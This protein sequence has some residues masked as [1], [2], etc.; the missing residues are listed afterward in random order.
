VVSLGR[1]AVAALVLITPRVAPVRAQGPAYLP[2][3][4]PVGAYLD[5]LVAR[6]ALP[7][8]SSL[9][10]PYIA[11]DVVTA[12][13]S[14]LRA[15]V[16]KLV[17][18]RTW[19][20]E[21]R[22]AALRAAVG[23]DIPWPCAE[24]S[25]VPLTDCSALQR[26]SAADAGVLA[27]VSLTPF[28]TAQTS[29]RRELMLAE[30]SG[31]APPG[32]DIRFAL[33]SGALAGV[34]R[35]RVD[36]ALKADPEFTGKKDRSITA[37][38]Q[39]AYMV[40]RSRL[41][42]VSAGRVARNWGPAP[43]DGLQ[44]GRYADTY[45]HLYLRLGVESLHLSSIVAR[46]DDMTVGTDSVAERYFT[47]HR[48]SAR[49]KGV[50][51]AASEAVVYG[52]IGR[53]F[54]PS[55]ANP[56]SLLDLLQ[57]TERKSLNVNYALDLAW[58]TAG[59]G[60]YA[61]QFLVDDFQFDRCGVRCQE[62]ASLGYSIV[63]EAMPFVGDARSFANY[64]RVTNLTYRSASPWER[65]TSFDL[66]LGR[67]QS[68]FDELRAGVELAPPLGGPLRL[69]G[70]YRR[71]GEGDYRKPFPPVSDNPTTP[72]IFAGVVTKVSR[73]GAAWTRSGHVSWTLDAGYN[74]V[75]NA[76]HV[77]GS[78]SDGFEGRLRLSISPLVASSTVLQQ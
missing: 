22:R 9:E 10:R 69:Y 44:V 18:P 53:G 60:L 73:I 31:G 41:A 51:I 21:V 56:F 24:G 59:H 29:G 11:R 68:D 37:R 30:G 34:A 19:Y 54:E 16:G 76:E 46:L 32:A 58:R 50:E 42:I 20:A 52:G 43:L 66:S 78:R 55:L 12:I 33:G 27:A 70:A 61:G 15:P 35:L 47:A 26:D 2:L 64:T 63:A 75:S 7:R 48:L 45:D 5:A 71:Q 36:R 65:Y 62:P 39:D 38:M 49:W 77:A 13:D 74:W 25:D 23:R 17:A 1:L 8:L 67:G 14:A 3:D 57:Y 4:E 28:V 40:G 6:G 72:L